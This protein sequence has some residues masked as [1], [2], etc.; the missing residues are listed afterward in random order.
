MAKTKYVHCSKQTPLLCPWVD[1]TATLIHDGCKYILVDEDGEEFA[2]VTIIV[3]KCKNYKKGE[4]PPPWMLKKSKDGS[5]QSDSPK[6][7]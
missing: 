3:T 2:E 4:L 6:S 1:G 5:T 7:H